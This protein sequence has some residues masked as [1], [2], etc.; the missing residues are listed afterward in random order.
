MPY[1]QEKQKKE[2][3]KFSWLNIQEYNVISI[4]NDNYNPLVH[5]RHSARCFHTLYQLIDTTL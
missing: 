2:R 1:R 5:A 3:I 4:D